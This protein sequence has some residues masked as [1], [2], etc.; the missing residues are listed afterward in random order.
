M[1]ILFNFA[2]F[3]QGTVSGAVGATASD[4]TIAAGAG[5][6]RLANIG[7]QI[8]FWKLNSGGASVSTDTPLLPNSV[9]M[10]SCPPGTSKISVIA[11]GAGSTL[12]VTPGTGN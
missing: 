4:I 2:P 12:Y 3:P 10:F 8:V 9:E 1:S 11:A 7:T 5:A 6:L